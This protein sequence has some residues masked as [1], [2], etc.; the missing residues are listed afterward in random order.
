[1]TDWIDPVIVKHP[2]G[3][4]W[5]ASAQIV[6]VKAEYCRH[7]CDGYSLL[8]AGVCCRVDGHDGTHWA[9]PPDRLDTPVVP[10]AVAVLATSRPLRPLTDDEWDTFTAPTTSHWSMSD[11]SSTLDDTLPTHPER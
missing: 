2:N 9:V 10:G 7:V 5:H 6:Y 8:W 1:M 4:T 11:A 3:S